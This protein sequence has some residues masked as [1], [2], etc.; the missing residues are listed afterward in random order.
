M[1]KQIA[2]KWIAALRSGK[3]KQTKCAL[4]DKDG[5]CCLGVLCAISP[6]K[7]NFTRMTNAPHAKN[8][9][10]PPIVVNWAGMRSSGGEYQVEGNQY[11]NVLTARNDEGM[12]FSEIAK[13]IEKYT[14]D[15]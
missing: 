5:Y 8:M 11:S 6:W 15:L 4:K 7:Y 2:K 13:L 12:S 3:Y 10:L 9:S 14:E 1:N